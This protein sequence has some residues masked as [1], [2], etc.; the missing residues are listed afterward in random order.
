MM[1]FEPPSTEQAS[2]GGVVRAERLTPEQRS[3][4]ARI[5]A[6][7][8]WGKSILEATHSG[9]ILIGD[10][11]IECA[12]LDDG[13]RVLSQSTVLMSLGR[14]PDKSRRGPGIEKR[15]PFLSAAN[16][17]PFI[18]PEL[19]DLDQPVKYRLPGISS[20][21][22]GYRAEILP[23][24]C[25]MYLDAEAAGALTAKQYPT[26]TAAKI[27]IRGLAEVGIIGLV[28]EA[29]GYQEV[30][31]RQE[32]QQILQAYVRAEF[33]PWVKRFPDEF[34]REIYRL[35]EWEFRPGTAKRTPFVG[36]LVRHYIYEQLPQGVIDELERLNP[37]DDRGRRPKRHHQYLTADT[38]HPHLDK[39]ISTVTTLMRV[40]ANQEEFEVLFER[41]FPPVNPRLPFIVEMPP[42]TDV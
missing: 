30:R 37:L 16:L 9:T 19:R 22:T 40:S 20:V 4:S 34:F 35:R 31:A 29:T 21:M 38:G 13:T 8:R 5:A 10:A 12:V 17:Q 23:R 27:L 2:R 39:Q 41:A 7:A 11:T 14:V 28:D 33:R 6:E 32:L 36:K 26:A 42:R 24:T 3:E 1:P 25:T 18:L 15:A